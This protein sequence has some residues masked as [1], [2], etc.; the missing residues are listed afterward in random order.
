MDQARDEIKAL[1]KQ[2]TK[3]LDG[4]DAAYQ[5]LQKQLQR[6]TSNLL[7]AHSEL[8]KAQSISTLQQRHIDSQDAELKRVREELQYLQQKARKASTKRRKTEST[9]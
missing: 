2:H 7:S 4:K 5:R 6:A 1:K 8:A 3:T 9:E